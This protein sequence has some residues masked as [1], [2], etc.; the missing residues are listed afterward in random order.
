MIL[1]TL[2]EVQR[3]TSEKKLKLIEELWAD[4]GISTSEDEFA[5]SNEHLDLSIAALSD[6]SVTTSWDELRTRLKSR[7]Q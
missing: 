1:E 4:L 2:P 6:R 7:T 3:L 5:V